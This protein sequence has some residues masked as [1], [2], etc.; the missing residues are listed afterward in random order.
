MKS[1]RSTLIDYSINV[2]LAH[3]ECNAPKRVDAAVV[4]VRPLA[5][6]SGGPT[7]EKPARLGH[8][9]MAKLISPRKLLAKVREYLP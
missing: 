3:I 5:L 9:Q 4:H 1:F 7:S 6:S 8:E 2:K